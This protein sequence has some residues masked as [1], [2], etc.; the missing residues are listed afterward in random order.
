M[1]GIIALGLSVLVIL[2]GLY[3][4][5]KSKK[6]SL[7]N[8]YV[9]SSYS[10]IILGGLLFAGTVIGGALMIRCHHSGNQSCFSQGHGDKC[11]SSSAC[12][13]AGKKCRSEMSVRICNV[14]EHF[15]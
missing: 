13:Y 15:E 1:I 4:L 14:I 3:L 10:A 9:F 12:S 7:S 6:E 11:G 5:S 8:L 2:G